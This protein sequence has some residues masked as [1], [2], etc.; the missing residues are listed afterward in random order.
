MPELQPS[1]R[2]RWKFPQRGKKRKNK[3]CAKNIND[4]MFIECIYSY[5]LRDS[6]DV[7]NVTSAIEFPFCALQLDK[8]VIHVHS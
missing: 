1:S 5:Y 7:F 4:S 3:R 8:G 2:G 6:E